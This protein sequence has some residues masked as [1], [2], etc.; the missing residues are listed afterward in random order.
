VYASLCRFFLSF[1][2]IPLNGL[3]PT[4]F[5]SVP[6][7]KMFFQSHK[8]WSFLMFNDLRWEVVVFFVMGGTVYHHFLNFLFITLEPNWI[9]DW[10]KDYAYHSM[11]W[12]V[13]YINNQLVEFT[14]S[15]SVC[16]Y[17]LVRIKDTNPHEILFSS[18]TGSHCQVFSFGWNF[19]SFLRIHI[20]IENDTWKDCSLHYPAHILFVNWKSKMDAITWQILT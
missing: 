6:I 8:S 2:C 9:S 20:Y 15:Y 10:P 13:V 3:T 1:V 16:W 5:V 14:S 4:P 11:T 17:K 18:P 19:K 12:H 7:Q